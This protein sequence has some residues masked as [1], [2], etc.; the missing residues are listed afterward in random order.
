MFSYFHNNILSMTF[1]HFALDLYQ[2]YENNRML[3]YKNILVSLIFFVFLVISA[4]VSAA[5]PNIVFILSDD[6]GIDAV[7]GA[8]WPNDLQCHTPNIAHLATQGRVFINARV[9][10]FCSP[11][12]AGIL[13]GRS[14]LHTGVIGN[15]KRQDGSIPD[16]DLVS[17]QGHES[18]IAEVLKS[19]GYYTI[20]I[21][22]WHCGYSV[23]RE[24]RPEQQGFDIAYNRF[25][26]Y[27]LD[28]P[29]LVG[30]EHISRMVNLAVDS[31]INRPDP[32]AP[33][34]LFFWTIEPHEDY[35]PDAYGH[36]WWRVDESLLPS[37]EQ[38]YVTNPSKDM[39]VDR[40]RANIEAMDTEIGRLL[41]SINVVDDNLDY[42][43]D[44]NTV[45]LY[46]GDNGTPREVAPRPDHA[47]GS[48]FDGGVKVP[49]VVLGQNV[50]NDG[51]LHERLVSHM[52]IYDTLADIAGAPAEMRGT[53]PRD[54]LS[55]ADSIGWSQDLLPQHEYT[56]S[57]VARYVMEDQ[58]VVLADAQYKLIARAG[59]KFMAPLATDQFYDLVQDPLEVND[60]VQNGM[61]LDQNTVY[62]RM[63]DQVVNYWASSVSEKTTDM[64]SVPLTNHLS[65]SSDNAHYEQLLPLGHV[66][67]GTP[68]A[69]EARVLFRFDISSIDSL[70]P[71][72]KTFDDVIAAQL[73]VTFN[74]DSNRNQ[75]TDTGVIHAYPMTLDWYTALPKWNQIVNAYK[76]TQQLGSLDL[77][78][79]VLIDPGYGDGRLAGIPIPS[80]TPLSLGQSADLLNLITYWHNNPTRNYGLVLIADPMNELG[81]FQYVSLM[82][83]AKIRLTLK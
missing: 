17:L 47:K 48:G 70:L 33:Y 74:K 9:N 35:Y 80:E 10:P 2:H 30:D 55:F 56:L 64:I 11:T 4:A 82:K 34:A 31:V 45:I 71:P 16:R 37:G 14:A 22:K 27:Y 12:R 1:G 53:A 46:M 43:P 25:D 58:Q 51:L 5:P 69:A 28:D 20:H 36:W 62:L 79:Y 50:P 83:Q 66:K 63:R 40:Y 65:I 39:E 21:D 59:G 8:N 76:T 78:P 23:E 67:P 13:S 7:E 49:F 18:T 26:Y 38:Y 3:L 42:Q 24:Q 44:S 54:G 60:L 73:I 81:G 15:I 29:N 72:G 77:P 75:D 6:I 41:R 61:D 57:S 52:D 68:Y 19:M 32:N